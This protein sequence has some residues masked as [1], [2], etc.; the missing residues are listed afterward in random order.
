MSG[1]LH[2]VQYT[3]IDHHLQCRM[4][5]KKRVDLIA[6]A[7]ATESL[8]S[9]KEAPRTVKGTP[10]RGT[11]RWSKLLKV[12]TL[13]RTI[14]IWSFAFIFAVKY[15][16]TTRKFTYGKKVSSIACQPQPC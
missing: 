13:Q 2:V 3:L 11:S 1:M 16:L 9:K 7:E 14:Q 12:S 4:E 15:L 6:A 5:E 8:T 10:Y